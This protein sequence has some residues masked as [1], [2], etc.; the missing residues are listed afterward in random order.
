MVVPI[1]LSF[2]IGL[3][4]ILLH[5]RS[6]TNQGLCSENTAIFGWKFIPTLIT[7]V[8][9]RFTGILL[10]NVQ[11]TEP[12]VRMARPSSG[13]PGARFTLL[14]KPRSWWVTIANGLQKDRNGGVR[15][16]VVVLCCMVHIL[17]VLVISPLSA[18]LLGTKF[19]ERTLSTAPMKR[20]VPIKESALEYRTDRG[21]FLRTTAALMQN[22]SSSPWVT[23]E[24]FVLPFWPA[25][26][27]GIQWT[28]QYGFPQRWS[29]TTHVFKTDLR[30]N[31]LQ[32]KGT[33]YYLRH[34]TDEES[35]LNLTYQPFL[36]SVMLETK[37]GCTYNLTFNATWQ[38]YS[39]LQMYT[40]GIGSWS[41]IDK[42]SAGSVQDNGARVILGG[43]CHEDES[44]IMTTQWVDI[45]LM[46]ERILDDF[47]AVGYVCNASYKAAEMP[48]HA[49]LTETS[50]TVEVDRHEFDRISATESSNRLSLLPIRDIMLAPEF[51]QYV[52]QTTGNG[53]FG[54][55]DAPALVPFQGATALLSPMYSQDI[56]ATIRDLDLP[57]KA[58]R[59]RRRFFAETLMTTFTAPETTIEEMFMGTRSDI[60]RRVIVSRPVAS[61]ICGVSILSVA[62]LTVVLSL[63]RSGHQELNTFHDPNTIAGVISLVASN[64]SL[65]SKFKLLSQC[66]RREL[67]AM[68]KDHVFV[69]SSGTLFEIQRDDERLSRGMFR[70][71]FFEWDTR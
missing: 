9:S 54:Y 59:I 47:S 68:I 48:V 30:C 66:N 2:T 55:N 40:S 49:S 44:I 41:R 14:E 57:N 67:K 42:F 70:S 35:R 8:Y 37:E 19:M 4:S 7:V 32:M 26:L 10:E 45:L 64:H 12:F 20:A 16:W 23:D 6:Q 38:G 62:M 25:E 50:F 46:E 29:A 61:V 34:Y 5:W 58:A 43:E 11:R 31:Q 21:T 13:V 3:G 27:G 52:P 17:A 51:F 71:M 53:S 63:L 33:E 69:T 22:Y 18:A 39:Q 56:A 24:Y 65:L 36:A 15:S 1:S 60:G 28:P